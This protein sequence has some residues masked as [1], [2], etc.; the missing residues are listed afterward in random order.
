MKVKKNEK[1]NRFDAF[2]IS[3]YCFHSRVD[4]IEKDREKIENATFEDWGAFDDNDNLAARII[5]NKYEFNIDG[6]F[7]SAGGIG[8]VSTLPEY[9]SSGAVRDIFNVLLPEAYKS[10][11]VISTLYPFKQAF[12][13]KF[14]Y[15]VITFCNNFEFKPAVL[16]GYHF[17]GRVKMW[18]PGDSVKE[19][20]EIYREWSKD[21][22]LSANRDEKAM[23][24]CMQVEKLYKDRQFSYIFSKDDKNIAYLIMKDIYNDPDAILRVKECAWTSPEGFNAI[25]GFLGRFEADYGTI[26]L[27]LPAGIDL[28][29]IIRTD[30]AYSIKKTP[31]QDFMARVINVQKLLETINKP[32]NTDFYIQVTDEIIPE[33]NGLWHVTSDYVERTMVRIMPTLCVNQRILAQLAI[34][35]LTMEEAELDSEVVINGDKDMLRHVFIQKPIYVGEHF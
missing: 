33:N 12:Y 19:Y 29:R 30:V 13:R 4:D 6:K 7:V 2:L 22:N 9:R 3:T 27:P 24:A 18:N 11:E 1:E 35:A 21:Y 16:N 14:G 34:G 28:Y 25:L 20:L 8:G 23:E 31:R 5:N 26:Q 17:D 15:E 10:G 32:E